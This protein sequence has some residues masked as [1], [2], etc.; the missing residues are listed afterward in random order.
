MGPQYMKAGMGDGGGCHPRDN[1]ALRYM[2]QELDL[3]YDL[4]DSI[5]N[6]REIQAENLALKLVNLA[7]KHNYPIYIHGKAYKP[8]VSYEDG[9]YSLLVGSYCSKHGIE[10]IYIDPMTDDINQPQE[11]CVILMAHSASTTYKYTGNPDSDTLYCDIPKNSVVVDP[12]RTY[13]NKNC[14]VIHYGNTRQK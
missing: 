5:M 9:S 10:P 7:N 4:F 11:P 8:K 12:W 14:T 2:A 1:I 13:K 6:A 3:G